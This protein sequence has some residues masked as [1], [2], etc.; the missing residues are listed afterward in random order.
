MMANKGGLEVE[1]ILNCKDL[2]EIK[3]YFKKD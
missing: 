2:E 3:D 1:D